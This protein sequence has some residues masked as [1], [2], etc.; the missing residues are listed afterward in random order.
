LFSCLALFAFLPMTTIARFLLWAGL[1]ILV[2]FGYAA[3]RVRDVS[4]G[5][6][7]VG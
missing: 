2:Y 7:P 4:P 1:G 3:R 6:S 5:P